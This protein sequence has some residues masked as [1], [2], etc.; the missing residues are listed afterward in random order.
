MRAF[1]RTGSLTRRLA[2]GAAV[3]A[4]WATLAGAQTLIHR[5][6]GTA[7]ADQWGYAVGGG[8]DV[9][10]DGVPDFIVGSPYWDGAGMNRGAARV[11]SGATAELIY[12]VQNAQDNAFFGWSVAIVGDLNNDGHAEF[13]VGAPLFDTG[14]TDCG[15]AYLYSG[16]TGNSLANFSGG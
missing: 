8:H 15:R 5:V 13:L 14:G 6:D 1:S 3:L 9:D 12:Q 10:G 4:C 16:S 11:F 2:A 7:A